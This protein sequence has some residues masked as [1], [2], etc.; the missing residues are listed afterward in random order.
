VLG[1]WFR[2]QLTTASAPGG[3]VD[4]KPQEAQ[5]SQKRFL[6]LLSILWFPPMSDKTGN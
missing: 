3:A 4:E 5:K 6:C 2:C 1:S